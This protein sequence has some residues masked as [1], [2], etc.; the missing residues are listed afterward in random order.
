VNFGVLAARHEATGGDIRNAVLKAAMA[1]AAEPGPDAR[2]MIHQRHLEDGIREVMTARQVMRQSL[3]SADSGGPAHQS[4]THRLGSLQPAPWMAL[5]LSALAALL[6]A[7][8][9]AVAAGS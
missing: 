7:L 4:A 9:L 8:A 5:S 1:A 2:K 6:A 3:F